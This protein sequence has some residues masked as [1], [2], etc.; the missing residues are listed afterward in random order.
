METSL[1]Q[2][3]YIHI[4]VAAVLV[5]G[6]VALSAYAYYALKQ[7]KYWMNGPMVIN[8]SGEGEIQAVP[9]I[10]TFSFGVRGEGIDATT[11]QNIS[12]EA[13]NKAIAF[14]QE[15]GVEE[16]DIKTSNYNLNPKYTWVPQVCRVGTFCP[17]GEQKIDGYE[18][19]QMVTVKVR[20][21]EKS[22]ELISGIGAQG[23]TDIS[24]LSFTIDD[25]S[26]LQSDARNLA[27]AD[28]KEQA[29]VL[30]RELG[31]SIVKMT[32]FYDETSNPGMPYY[33]MGGDMMAKSEMAVAPDM[34]VGENTITSR[35]SLSFEVK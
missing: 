3:K 4:L 25:M 24:G 6:T 32:S 14:L 12:A 30:A 35:V 19:Y 28:A 8:V 34:P 27:I 26:E 20:D 16:K 10:G 31:V 7:S 33:G 11:A 5:A 29:E 13:M 22:G 9:D 17:G 15:A 2:K 1:W 23:A 18:V 21:L